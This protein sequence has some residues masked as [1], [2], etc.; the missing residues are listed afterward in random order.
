MVSSAPERTSGRATIFLMVSESV[1]STDQSPWS[2]SPISVFSLENPFRRASRE[3]FLF[4]RRRICQR[5]FTAK[6]NRRARRRR[7]PMRMAWHLKVFPG[8]IVFWFEFAPHGGAF[9]GHCMERQERQPRVGFGEC[10]RRDSKLGGF[11][12]INPY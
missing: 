3:R 6:E 2:Q 4:R 5:G 9:E 10:Q 8:H 11:L 1:R 12:C 7:L